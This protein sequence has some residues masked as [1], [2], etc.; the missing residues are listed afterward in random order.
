V[1]AFIIGL[2]EKLG[3][4]TNTVSNEYKTIRGLMRGARR[5]MYAKGLSGVRV[6]IYWNWDNC[7]GNPDSTFIIGDKS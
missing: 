4:E 6:D 1:R 2:P 7:Y 3:T 5:Y